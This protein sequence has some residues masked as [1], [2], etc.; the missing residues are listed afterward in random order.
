MDFAGK[1]GKLPPGMNVGASILAAVGA[2]AF[3]ISQ[4]MF[5]G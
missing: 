5:T 4:S 2:A 3:G 1:V